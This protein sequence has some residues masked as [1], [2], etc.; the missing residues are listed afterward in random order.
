MT[1]T[2][3]QQQREPCSPHRDDA[4][5]GV[6]TRS[7]GTRRE[8]NFEASQAPLWRRRKRGGVPAS[9]ESSLMLAWL[10]GLNADLKLAFF[11]LMVLGNYALLPISAA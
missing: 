7:T 4:R 8:E 2:P 1:R 5:P 11:L 3:H 10:L 9:Q 6:A